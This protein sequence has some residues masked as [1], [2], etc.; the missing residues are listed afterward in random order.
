VQLQHTNNLAVHIA[1]TNVN[2]VKERVETTREVPESGGRVDDASSHVSASKVLEIGAYL[3]HD[4]EIARRML[5]TRRN[6]VGEL[7]LEHHCC[8]APAILAIVDEC[9][10]KQK[11]VA[12]NDHGNERAAVHEVLQVGD[13]CICLLQ[14]LIHLVLVG[15]GVAT[16]GCILLLG[17]SVTLANDC[18]VAAQDV[19][20]ERVLRILYSLQGAVTGPVIL[21]VRVS[22]PICRR[23]GLRVSLRRANGRDVARDW[24]EIIVHLDARSGGVK[25]S[26][27]VVM[28]V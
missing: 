15:T 20:N 1:V 9:L 12:V 21:G 13:E 18:I 3:D 26:E 7:I 10:I 2:N 11:T 5:D 14:L 24:W 17:Q 27:C 6:P 22:G 8:S 19:F 4:L 23:C 28:D 16:G 25:N